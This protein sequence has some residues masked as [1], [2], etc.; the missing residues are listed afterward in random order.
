MPLLQPS[1]GWI[2]IV[3]CLSGASPLLAQGDAPKP[4]T[5][6]KVMGQPPRWKPY[7]GAS[8]AFSDLGG[9]AASFGGYGMVGMYKDLINPLIG[10]G[11]SAEGY[12]GSIAGAFDG[13]GRL[14]L[15]LPVIFL[16]AGVDYGVKE[17]EFDFILSFSVP[18]R[19]GGILGHGSLVRLDWIPAR[20]ETLNLGF[21]VPIFQP[22]AG[23]TRPKA[24]DIVIPRAPHDQFSRADSMAKADPSEPIAGAVAR[25][26]VEALWLI[27][28]QNVFYQ[29]LAKSYEAGLQ[30]QKDTIQAYMKA[31]SRTD[32]AHPNGWNPS[33]ETE[34][35]H[36]QMT[37]AFGLAAGG[38]GADALTQWCLDCRRGAPCAA[39]LG[40]DPV[41]C[42]IRPVQGPEPDLGL[43][44]AGP[45]GV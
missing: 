29:A 11:I 32:A 39:R 8:A 41:R 30:T 3:M 23:K 18:I 9:G 22:W 14:N 45:A 31:A 7:L 4:P 2:A 28:Q 16:Q 27:N 37:M 38:T 15:A 17:Q 35:W 36:T 42:T 24:Q 43:W 40:A 6:Y 34:Q 26:R 33:H 13:G 20:N 44:R 10:V 12:M 25:M 1:V 19:R 21:Q 5:I